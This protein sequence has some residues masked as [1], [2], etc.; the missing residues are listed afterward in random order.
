MTY[1]LLLGYKGKSCQTLRS[2]DLG[3]VSRVTGSLLYLNRSLWVVPKERSPLRGSGF[4][5]DEDV[6]YFGK[7]STFCYESI[8]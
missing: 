3:E 6:K 4:H 2:S 1:V 7:T 8:L 5:R